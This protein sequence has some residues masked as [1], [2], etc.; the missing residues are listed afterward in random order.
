MVPHLCL[1]RQSICCSSGARLA[2]PGL[3]HSV[4]WLRCP[5]WLG[6]SCCWA[7]TGGAAGGTGLGLSLKSSRVLPWVLVMVQFL[8]IDEKIANSRAGINPSGALLS[9]TFSA[10]GL[11]TGLRANLAFP[12][13]RSGVSYL[14]VSP[15]YSSRDCLSGTRCPR[16]RRTGLSR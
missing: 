4:S 15:L 9:S 2:W 13:S 7:A 12:H 11:Q 10:W 16:S 8:V 14:R 1:A 6:P 5:Q 3:D